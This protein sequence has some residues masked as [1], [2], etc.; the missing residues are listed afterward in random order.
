MENSFLTVTLTAGFYTLSLHDALPI[1]V[2]LTVSYSGSLG[3]VI[4]RTLTTL[5]GDLTIQP[6]ILDGG[7]KVMYAEGMRTCARP[8]VV[9][10]TSSDA[11]VLRVVT[12]AAPGGAGAG[13]VTIG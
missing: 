9:T 2:P 5:Q 7:G 13:S 12:A 1:L 6:V 8:I 11:T 4:P 10:V 3:G